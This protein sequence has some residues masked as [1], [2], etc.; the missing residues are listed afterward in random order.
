MLLSA[1]CNLIGGVYILLLFFMTFSAVYMVKSLTL[2]LKG[3]HAPKAPPPEAEPAKPQPQKGYFVM[4][5]PKKRR[6]RRSSP[7]KKAVGKLYFIPDR[8]K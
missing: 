3:R 7:T 5:Q 6:K 2:F 4:E 8:E 1:S